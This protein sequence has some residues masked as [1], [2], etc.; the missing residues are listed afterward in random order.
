MNNSDEL[1]VMF[2]CDQTKIQPVVKKI[3]ASLPSLTMTPVRETRN[4]TYSHYED[5]EEIKA[6]SKF[7]LDNVSQKPDSRG[8]E[9]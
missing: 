5:T 8:E 1:C 9:G 3:I 2:T 6:L 7:I 4:G